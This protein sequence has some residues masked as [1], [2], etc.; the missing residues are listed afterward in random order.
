MIDF[1]VDMARMQWGDNGRGK[2]GEKYYMGT[3]DGFYDVMEKVCGDMKEQGIGATHINNSEFTELLTACAK[4]VWERWQN[5]EKE[6]WCDYCGIGGKLLRCSGC[7]TKKVWYCSPEHQ[8]VR[9]SHPLLALA[10][11][12]KRCLT[13][14]FG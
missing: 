11:L 12:A 2:F 5:R 1:I 3:L 7:R 13:L 14:Q 4:R 8:K 9:I 6:G 10:V